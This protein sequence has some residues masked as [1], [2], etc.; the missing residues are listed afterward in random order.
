[1]NDVMKPWSLAASVVLAGA[2]VGA[3]S[4]ADVIYPTTDQMVGDADGNENGDTVWNDADGQ[5]NVGDN[6]VNNNGNITQHEWRIVMEF[7]LTASAAEI[8]SASQ[9]LLS[10]TVVTTEGTP[11]DFDL[12]HMTAGNNG[13]IIAGDYQAAGNQ[14]GDTIDAS[15]LTANQTLQFDVTDLVK[16]DVGDG[17]SAFRFQVADPSVAPNGNTVR[18]IVKFYDGSSGKNSDDRK[19][20]LILVPEP[21]SLSLVAFGVFAVMGRCSGASFSPKRG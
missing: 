18:D 20:Q 8:A 7:P 13:T 12:I 3:A 15:T 10:V 1:M 4:R 21:G 2:M 19:P 17:Y 11:Y 14:V 6:Y 5:Y 9:I 16:A